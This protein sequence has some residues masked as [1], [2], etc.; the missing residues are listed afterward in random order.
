MP[1]RKRLPTLSAR[2]GL[3]SFRTPGANLMPEIALLLPDGF[4]CCPIT[5]PSSRIIVGPFDHFYFV[6]YGMCQRDMCVR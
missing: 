5:Q 4:E 3:F 6:F 1:A 2:K